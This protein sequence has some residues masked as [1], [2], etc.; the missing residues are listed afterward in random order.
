M[1]LPPGTPP[2][3]TLIDMIEGYRRALQMQRDT[4]DTS[5]IRMLCQTQTPPELLPSLIALRNDLAAASTAVNS[6]IHES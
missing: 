6:C 4:F 5:G 2:L 1:A 3:K